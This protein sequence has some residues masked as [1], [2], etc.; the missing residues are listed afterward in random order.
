MKRR[1][2]VNRTGKTVLSAVVV[3]ALTALVGVPAGAQQGDAPAAGEVGI[4]K[5]EIRIAVIADVDNPAA[6][7]VFQ[8]QVDGMQAYAKYVNANGG[9]AGRKLVVDFIDSKLSADEARNA[10]ITACSDDFAMV[11]TAVVFMNNVDDMV[12][13]KDSTGA[14]TGLPDINTFSGE[15]VH[16][17]SAVSYS[18]SPGELD[19]STKDA[20]NKTFRVSFGQIR[21]YL[22]KHKK[23]H[24]ICIIPSDLKAAETTGRGQCAAANKLGVGLDGP[25]YYGVSALAPQSA[26]TSIIG[27]AKADGSTYVSTL[28]SAEQAISVRREAKL[29]GLS[30]VEVWDCSRSCYTDDFLTGGADIEGEYV[31]LNTLPLNEAKHNKALKGYLKF[32]GKDKAN[33]FGE[34]AWAAAMLFHETINKIVARDGINGITRAKFLNELAST[35]QFDAGGLLASTDI[36]ARAPSDCYALVQVRDNTF[37]R[38]NP[39]KPGTFDCNPKNIAIVEL[40]E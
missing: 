2:P 36:G 23:L 39:K 6:P 35:E 22:S 38:V 1:K 8:G 29:Q 16:Q 13:C 7:G 27:A 4:T 15:V 9:I 33:A 30:T 5:K 31:Y 34:T 21:Y 3:L 32:V 37:A 11:G 18:V 10:T 40:S 19:C 12:A 20:A 14:A 25:G 17:C 26:L 28:T 24:G